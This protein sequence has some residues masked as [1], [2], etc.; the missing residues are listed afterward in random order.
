ML[1]NPKATKFKK[2]TRINI[3]VYAGSGGFD[4]S[5]IEKNIVVCAG[6]LTAKVNDSWWG[7]K[8][9][10][11][12]GNI[13]YPFFWTIWG[14]D[15]EDTP[16]VGRQPFFAAVQTMLP[17]SVR[18]TMVSSTPTSSSSSVINSAGSVNGSITSLPT[19]PTTP[20]SKGSSS[21]QTAI[22]AGVLCSVGGLALLLSLVFLVRRRR[23]ARHRVA[24]SYINFTADP[25]LRPDPYE[26][27]PLYPPPSASSSKAALDLEMRSE[28]QAQPGVLSSEADNP[29][30]S[31]ENEE[32]R[33]RIGLLT[34]E[35]E[36]LRS[37]GAET[38]P[39]YSM[40]E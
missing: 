24:E 2:S 18:A 21:S 33:R 17:D 10:T 39:A 22:I 3:T 35:V 30:V 36:R 28:L 6:L 4:D 14:V 40:Q 7:E 15:Q 34:E 16:T 38:P 29:A 27:Q 37:M 13:S 26:K 8:G 9:A 23:V 31:S 32:L 5:I 12:T 19:G 20:P 25:I 1:W 11:W